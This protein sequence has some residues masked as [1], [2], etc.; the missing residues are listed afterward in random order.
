M[1]KNLFHLLIVLTLSLVYQPTNIYAAK[2][3]IPKNSTAKRNITG[4]GIP[5]L[6]LYRSDKLGILLSFAN[7]SGIQSVSYLFTYN[8]NGIQQ[9]AGG[10]I[11]KN[12]NPM[13]ERQLLFGTCSTNVCTYHYNLTNAR[14]TLTAKYSN[15][16]TRTKLYKIKTYQ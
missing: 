9:G 16:T 14:L 5:A 11:S 6:V 10:T 12:N 13:L 8:T 1:R 3:F 15:G 7:F 2:K 4:K